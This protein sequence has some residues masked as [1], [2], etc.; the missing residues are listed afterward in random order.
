MLQ[1]PP[2]IGHLD[3]GR[4]MM[5][6]RIL[7]VLTVAAGM[8][9]AG[10]S[11]S[12]TLSRYTYDSPQAAEQAAGTYLDGTGPAAEAA[13]QAETRR[14]ARRP[15]PATAPGAPR[16][17]R[18]EDLSARTTGSRTQAQT[19]ALKPYSDEWWEK[20]RREDAR[21]KQKMNICRGC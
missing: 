11:S 18:A 20:E 6:H 2:G 8:A 9:L 1:S 4:Q 15:A 10:C 7:A 12:S 13:E 17:A 19:E 16:A 14:Q 21:L 5:S 3:W